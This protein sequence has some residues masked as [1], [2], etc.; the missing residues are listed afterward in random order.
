M[1]GID[2]FPCSTVAIGVRISDRRS[3]IH[4]PFGLDDLFDGRLKPNR[5]LPLPHVYA[6][7]TAR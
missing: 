1:G 2:R 6:E 7:K 3:E 5:A 4:A